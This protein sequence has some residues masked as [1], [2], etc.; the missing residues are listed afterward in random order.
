MPVCLSVCICI[1]ICT[2]VCVRVSSCTQRVPAEKLLTAFQ[3]HPESWTRVDSI[4]E[5]SRYQNTKYFAL[6]VLE[7]VIKYRWN[8]LPSDQREGIKQY[9]SNKIIQIAT[10]EALYKS[11]S[12]FL[13]KLNLILVQILKHDWPARWQSFIPDIVGASKQS[14]TLCE[15]MMSVLKMLSEEVFDF[16][17][18]EMTQAKVRDLK[19]S[20][21]SEFKLIYELCIFALEKSQRAELL[22]STMTTLHAFL[23]WI[24]LGYIFE[25]GL[26]NV[27][28]KFLP[29]PQFRNIALKC[30]TE[31]GS[32]NVGSL[33]DSQFIPLYSIFMTQLQTMLPFGVVNIPEAYNAGSD[34]EQQ[35]IQNLASFFTAF[36][37]AHISLLEREPEQLSALLAGLEYLI[38]ISYVEE[39]EVFKI[40]L[41]YWHDFVSALYSALLQT[42]CALD[43]MTPSMGSHLDDAFGGSRAAAAAAATTTTTATMQSQGGMN[44]ARGEELKQMYRGPLSKL[45]MLMICRM[46]KPEEVILVEDENGNI[47]RETMKDSDVLTRYKLMRETLIY[48]SHLDHNDTEEQMTSK[49]KKQLSGEEWSW[50]NL[51]TLCWAIGSI[52]GSMAEDQESRFLVNVIRDLLT[53][54][55]QTK[56]KEHK[57]VIASNIMYVVGQYP[58]FLRAHWKFLKTVVNKLFEFMHEKFPGV[59]EMACDTFLK[60]SGKCR[61]RFVQTQ[62][63]EDSP[64][65]VELLQN[66]GSIIVDLEYSHIHVFYEAAGLM[67]GAESGHSLRE[68]Y[69]YR[70]MEPPNRIWSDIIARARADPR[71]LIEK[72]VPPSI[73][74]IIQTNASVC[75]SLGQAFYT[76]MS[77]IFMDTLHVYMM[78]ST[79]I[80]AAI[81]SGGPHAAKSTHVKSLRSVKKAILRMIETYVDTTED[82]STFR[83]QYVP[84]MMDPIL[85]DYSRNV[86]DARDSEVLSL[87]TTII[88][89]LKTQMMDEVVR[90]FEATFECT[91]NMITK[92]FE[93]YPEHRLRF[94]A[95]LRAIAKHCFMALY[96]LQPVQLK[97]VVDS[98][99]W[100]FR[101]TERNVAET[102]LLLLI[103]LMTSFQ[104]SD[105]ADAFFQA[106]YLDIMREIFAVLTDTFHKPGFKLHAQVLQQLFTVVSDG[107][108]TQPL[109][110]A[111]TPG[112]A[113]FTSNADFVRQRTRQ[114]LTTSFPN[115]KPAD[116]ASFVDGMFELS[117]K[118]DEFSVFKS[119]LRDFLVASK[120][121]A[122]TD[123]AELYA[124]ETE[125]SSQENRQHLM[126][127]P[128]MIG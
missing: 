47:V 29:M 13:Q 92:N 38:Q 70:L 103:D 77:L 101:H 124:D 42:E 107:S 61:K 28:L 98:V 19:N 69:L 90:I 108:L 17:R 18:G 91:I 48:L 95:L 34:D 20:L 49:L 112:S 23:S 16:S 65:I 100:A 1:C 41:D 59:K 74:H 5:T 30:L 24:P 37:R 63:G 14:E 15:N 88:N 55:E 10:N 6:Q 99:V 26:I 121:F 113:T 81:N 116:V 44:S 7:S 51:N 68:E 97:L 43:D 104:K 9:V 50:H 80:S 3:E 110:D 56:G 119:H 45:R 126:A 83:S 117:M 118:K 25:G 85:G 62:H 52:S 109:W 82:L 93:D 120:E 31:I 128:G 32:L 21:N 75:V 53:L 66:L 72:D 58:R 57:A 40:T 94:I 33:Y 22:R 11:E 105:R 67:V 27:L 36:F 71:V 127:I 86:P 84:A 54:C 73:A 12:T 4:L 87:F 96:S 64:F 46:A 39:V 123:N 2:Y 89:K 122:G 35:F 78:Y 8:A 79:E 76:Q 106:Y 60:I 125:K 114:L 102:G 115:M 111:G